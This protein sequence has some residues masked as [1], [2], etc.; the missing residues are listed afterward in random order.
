MATRL[1]LDGSMIPRTVKRLFD[2]R[3]EPRVEMYPASAILG[4]RNREHMVALINLSAS[5]A[6]IEFARVPRIG[7]T[8]TLRTDGLETVQA[9]VRWACDGR[10]G[11]HFGPRS[12]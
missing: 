7:E 11:I 10:I 4:F 8:V 9:R 12:E 2:H 6:M 3:S 5:G 1:K